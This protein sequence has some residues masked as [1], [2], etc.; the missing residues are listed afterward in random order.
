MDV[1]IKKPIDA[2]RDSCQIQICLDDCQTESLI[3]GAD[4]EASIVHL[5]ILNQSIN[6]SINQ[7]SIHHLLANWFG[8][9]YEANEEFVVAD[10]EAPIVHLHIS[11]GH[12]VHFLS[13]SREFVLFK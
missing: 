6:Q 2:R 8:N 13:G 5:H 7:H 1:E 11:N 12:G 9:D 4:E 3:V 10:V